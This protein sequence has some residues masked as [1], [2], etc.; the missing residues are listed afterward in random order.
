M[1][2]QKNHV[3]K[4]KR[5]RHWIE[6]AEEICGERNQECSGIDDV[7]AKLETNFSQSCGC[8]HVQLWTTDNNVIQ[9]IIVWTY[10]S[11]KHKQSDE[12]DK[13]GDR[14]HSLQV[15]EN[16]WSWRP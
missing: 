12:E 13:E 10:L 14:A 4:R 3:K 16:S 2:K 7:R 11:G 9:T 1:Q 6:E 8:E 5:N 15:F